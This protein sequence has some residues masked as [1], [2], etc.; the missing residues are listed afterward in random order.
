[1]ANGECRIADAA[2]NSPFIIGHS[3]FRFALPKNFEF[4]AIGGRRAAV[5]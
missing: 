1:M 3:T 4:V 2:R 5:V